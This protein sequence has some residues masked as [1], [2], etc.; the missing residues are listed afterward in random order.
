[1]AIG[2][3][4][5]N[6]GHLDAAAG[7]AGLIK[8]ALSLTHRQLPAS[9]HFKEANPEID[10]AGGPFYVNTSLKAWEGRNG[11]PLRAGVSSFGIGG[12]NAHAI[13]EE[14]PA[15]QA[16]A[17]GRPYQLLS[18]S[19]KT[20]G[21][22]Q[23]YFVALKTFLG[24]ETDV[25]V[26]DMSYTLQVGRKAFGFRQSIV[27]KDK[28]ELIGLL[29]EAIAVPQPLKHI[30]SHS[31]IVFMFP[32]QGSQYAGMGL[33]LYE[34]DPVFRLEMDHGFALLH[35]LTGKDFKQLLYK[36]AGQDATLINSTQ[37][38][39]PLLFLIEYS[40]SRVLI[41]L[42]IV[43]DS[44]I[45]HS[46]GEYT[47]ACISGVFSLEDALRLVVKRGELM[48]LVGEGL[49][50]S[51]AISK[52]QGEAY[53]SADISLAAVNGPEQI[54]LSG[55]RNSIE[56]LMVLLDEQHIVYVKLH[57]SHA[58]HSAMQDII[59]EDFRAVLNTL[60]FGKPQLPFISNLT[61]VLI[62]EQECMSADYWV[63]HL[64]ETV[65]FSGGIQHL[66]SE[67]PWQAFIE[68]GAGHS[69]SSLLKQQRGKTDPVCV[70]LLRPVKDNSDDVQYF[71]RQLGHLWCEG[72]VFDWESYY[73]DEGRRRISLP[74]YSFEPVSYPAEVDP[75]GSEL[76]SGFGLS[77]SVSG[78]TGLKDWIY[79]PSWKRA[80][81]GNTVADGGAK[82][83]LIFS[84]EPAFTEALAAGLS[85]QGHT[86][87]VVSCG[88]RY[89][90]VSSVEYVLNPLEES[91]YSK[92]IRDLET[93]GDTFT[94]IVYGWGMQ[95][96]AGGLTL[97][98]DQRSLHLVYFGL[99]L[100]IQALSAKGGLAGKSVCVLTDSLYEVIGTESVHYSQSLGLG[101]VNVLPQETGVSCVH[102]DIELKSLGL[103]GMQKLVAEL[104]CNSSE[105]RRIVAHRH[106]QRWV[107][108]YQQNR[109]ELERGKSAVKE[110]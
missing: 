95:V 71:L 93:T 4:K 68:V 24:E 75:F 83:Y 17:A 36:S 45:G 88:E 104:T 53:L 103:D 2:S 105:Q 14:A 46:I 59:L 48:S 72:I 6:I 76:L 26:G 108:D 23:R 98:N 92:L 32:G 97:S 57:T 102:V 84:G 100:F 22:L 64:R 39:Q 99:V 109:E 49:M 90:R 74:T 89:Q 66:L 110:G 106:G 107:Q 7:V 77:E 78:S 31:G 38:A 47:A 50:L 94:D 28:E 58:F 10:F 60:K 73:K 51:V 9:L 82:V 62:M 52:A 37:Y 96:P 65:N 43:P 3:V 29:E 56:K 35:K 42:G 19:A 33:G 30:E 16:G 13:L 70:N 81:L 20:E 27:Y 79:Y 25:N 12:T 15:V 85:Q 101:L 91:D 21:S 63:R 11:F 54:V 87:I 67:R 86:V 1:C 44:M 61:G 8:T 41:S 18:V 55:N 80:V 69:L 34:H 40:L 5:T